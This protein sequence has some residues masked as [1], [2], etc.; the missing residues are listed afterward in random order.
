MSGP[1][2][3]SSTPSGS[4]RP[5]VDDIDKLLNREANAFNREMEVDRILKAFKLK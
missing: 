1:A 5:A 3:S 4:N 2:S